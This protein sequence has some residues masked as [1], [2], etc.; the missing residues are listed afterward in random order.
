MGISS[1]VHELEAGSKCPEKKVACIYL[2]QDL[3][4]VASGRNG[5]YWDGTVCGSK[6]A[7]FN[8]CVHAEERASRSARGGNIRIAWSSY[9]P[10][11][12]CARIFEND[13]IGLVV[14]ENIH[15][16]TGGILQL[17][18]KSV[19]MA[20][21][22]G[23]ELT[24]MPGVGVVE[25][26]LCQRTYVE[27]QSNGRE[28]HGLNAKQ[29]RLLQQME[30]VRTHSDNLTHLNRRLRQ[31]LVPG[32]PNSESDRSVLEILSLIETEEYCLRQAERGVL[33]RRHP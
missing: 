27:R 1:N 2:T 19:P 14:F 29:E 30:Y 32:A 6:R 26:R 16:D 23:S 7:G 11:E 8:H 17:L 15:R 5:T 31:L 18:S 25:T 9:S 3:E 20:F 13:H 4:E 33:V 24:E 21:F 12:R 10:C 28:N 22:D